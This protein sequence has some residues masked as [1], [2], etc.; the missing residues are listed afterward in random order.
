ME[1]P[2]SDRDKHYKERFEAQRRLARS[3]ASSL[4]VNEILEKLREETRV[5]IPKAME[6]CILLLDPAAPKYTRPLQCALYDSP[7]NCLS[8]K[9]DRPAIQ[10]AMAKRKAVLVHE[11]EPI[12]RPDDSSVEIGPEMPVPV[13][14]GDEIVAVV[15]VVSRPGTRFTRQDFYLIRDLAESVGHVILRAKRHWDVTQEKIQ[16]SQV[17]GHLSPFVPLSVRN[18]VEKNPELANLEK[19]KRDVTVLFLDMENYTRLS[20]IRTETEVN[21]IVE[22]LFST[23]VDPIHR[24]NGDIVETAGDGLMIVF[25]NNDAL[26]NAVNGVK[27]AM[28]I[29]EIT[30][31]I[32]A[33]N[34]GG[35]EPIRI[36]MGLNS[37][38]ALVGMT[39][40]E[41]SL[42]TRMTYTASGPVTNLAAR[43][44]DHAQGGEILIGEETKRLI[45]GIYPT[46]DRGLVRLKG[47]ESPPRVFA[48][49]DGDR[50]Y[51]ESPDLD[52]TP[53][54]REPSQLYRE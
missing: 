4:E 17:L 34:E 10:K 37:G 3:I 8:C 50:E 36:N 43:L 54:A 5:L 52:N 33:E 9:R 16:I 18:I 28:D 45:E 53:P 32:I 21:D 31:K 40:F 23:F 41:G 2:R 1:Q 42:G 27:A 30:K 12:V 44:A 46:D 29:C 49:P 35:T 19:E 51:P 25:Q 14:V 15:S 20:T 13:I 11:S 47:I 48:I 24:S 22:R 39:R 6:A 7:L 38:S 26:T